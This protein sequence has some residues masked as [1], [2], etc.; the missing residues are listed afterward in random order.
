MAGLGWSD[1]AN[2]YSWVW[3]LS[4]LIAAFAGSWS[5]NP[6]V[7]RLFD[8]E[9]RRC[10]AKLVNDDQRMETSAEDEYKLI[11][12]HFDME[13]APLIGKVERV[14]YVFG[15]MFGGAFALISGWLVL[16][17]FAAWVGEIRRPE[18]P[19]NV[20]TSVEKTSAPRLAYYHLYLYGNALSLLAGLA[21][22]LVGLH[23]TV[24]LPHLLPVLLPPL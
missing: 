20:T 13:L 19:E 9:M 23:L 2:V 22:G 7:F 15:I 14:I 17:A 3:I 18:T 21:L 6:I 5:V 11:K 8:A 24:Y 1:I 16:K 10:A 4:F 12:K